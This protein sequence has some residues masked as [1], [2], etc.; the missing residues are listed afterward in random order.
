MTWSPIIRWNAGIRPSWGHLRPLYLSANPRKWQ[1]INRLSLLLHC[2]R[3]QRL[4][5]AFKPINNSQFSLSFLLDQTPRNSWRKYEYHMN[6]LWTIFQKHNKTEINKFKQHLNS[7]Q[8]RFQAYQHNTIIFE[9]ESA[10]IYHQTLNHALTSSSQNLFSVSFESVLQQLRFGSYNNISNRTSDRIKQRGKSLKFSR[11]LSTFIFS[12]ISKG[13]QLRL[14]L[15]FLYSS[16][17]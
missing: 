8:L 5:A 16:H 14:T 11:R 7:F 10:S 3:S 9:L 17:R 1:S 15:F 13:N 12:P 6:R 4:A 2:R